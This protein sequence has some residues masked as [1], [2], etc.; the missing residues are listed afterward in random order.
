MVCL[1]ELIIDYRWTGR[2]NFGNPYML[3]PQVL[4]S[5]PFPSPLCY[6][7]LQVQYDDQDQVA[8]E[9]TFW[10]DVDE[11]L[12]SKELFPYLR[13]IRIKASFDASHWIDYPLAIPKP[14]LEGYFPI[15]LFSGQLVFG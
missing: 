6:L 8:N 3:L 13:R 11:L 7:K 9:A 2:Q 15:L 12:S 10:P 5:L 4:S 14:N 1:E